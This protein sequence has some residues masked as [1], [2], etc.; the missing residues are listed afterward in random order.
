MNITATELFL[1]GAR[2]FQSGDKQRAALCFAGVIRRNRNHARAW[3]GLG[4]SLAGDEQRYCY[5]MALEIDNTL[6]D[7][8]SWTNGPA[9]RP[10][11]LTEP[12]PIF[13][14]WL[15]EALLTPPTP[16]AAPP[17][18]PP[19]AAPPSAAPPTPPISRRQNHQVAAAPAL[20]DEQLTELYRQIDHILLHLVKDPY[21]I[22]IW[23]GYGKRLRDEM[24]G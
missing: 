21:R 8:V 14:D 9:R 7:G 22:G 6:L 15:A 18:A 10:S 19:S 2:F 24:I 12:E 1:A 23:I 5:D 16:P 4:Q 3:V 17:A 20:A 11:I 13:E